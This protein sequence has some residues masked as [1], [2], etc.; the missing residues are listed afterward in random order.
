M[1]ETEIQDTSEVSTGLQDATIAQEAQ[2]DHKKNINYINENNLGLPFLFL[3]LIE[4]L[5]FLPVS[6]LHHSSEL[7]H[8]CLHLQHVLSRKRNKTKIY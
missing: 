6:C 4:E 2:G 3:K 5:H 7:V 8:F 1:Q